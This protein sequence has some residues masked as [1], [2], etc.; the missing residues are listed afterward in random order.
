MLF[1]KSYTAALLCPDYDPGSRYLHETGS[2]TV[3]TGKNLAKL[4]IYIW[5]VL[6]TLSMV[7]QLKEDCCCVD[8]K[9]P[10]HS[11]GK[12]V[13]TFILFLALG[14]AISVLMLVVVTAACVC[15]CA[16]VVFPDASC[17]VQGIGGDKGDLP[18][19]N[20]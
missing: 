9:S 17:T 3:C 13:N 14:V 4:F 7:T 5:E 8:L 16:A 18:L 6:Q 15:W 11:P 10:P 19:T 12:A 2:E 1:H 20:E